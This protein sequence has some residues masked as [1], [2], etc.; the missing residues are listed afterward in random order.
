MRRWDSAVGHRVEE[1]CEAITRRIPVTPRVGVI[2]GSGQGGFSRRVT[3]AGYLA[4]EDVPHFYRP[5]VAGHDG[6]VAIGEVHGVPTA[7]LE[8]RI[9]QYEGY[10]PREV[11]FPVRVLQRLGVRDLI[12]SCSAGGLH[13]SLRIGQLM[14]VEDHLNLTGSNPLTGERRGDES[15]AFLC[16]D[17]VYD[18][19]LREIALEAGRALGEEA[20]GGVLAGV[21]G[22]SYETPAERRML[23]MLGADAVTMSTVPEVI[24]A[25][26]LGMR[27]LALAM[28]TN[29]HDS[30]EPP[31]HREVLAVAGRKTR[32]LADVLERVVSQLPPGTG[33]GRDSQGEERT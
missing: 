7:V 13:P 12:L 32:F 2:L 19:T 20:R 17:G 18:P 25:R 9:H 11:V 30:S 10:F 26:F 16:M 28:I 24:M 27:V 14:I 31:D 15:G 1:A 23:A 22:P 33:G 21:S 3:G 29:R 4:Y 5:S 8:G 6:V